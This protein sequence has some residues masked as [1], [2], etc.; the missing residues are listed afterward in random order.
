MFLKV[1][2]QLQ[3]R[4]KGHLPHALLI[5]PKQA[6]ASHTQATVCQSADVCHNLRR[7]AHWVHTSMLM[8]ML[9]KHQTATCAHHRPQ[10]SPTSPSQFSGP[11]R[12]WKAQRP[13]ATLNPKFHDMSQDVSG[14]C[15]TA[16][17]GCCRRRWLPASREWHLHIAK[18]LR[19]IRTCTRMYDVFIHIFI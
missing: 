18:S 11:V 1:I 3:L 8:S 9:H 15:G 13:T 17:A 12:S 4:R 5:Q 14:S 16:N 2:A 7:I 6:S 10:S 19:I